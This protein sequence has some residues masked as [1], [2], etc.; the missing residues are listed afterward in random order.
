[1][2]D[3]SVTAPRTR[4]VAD[5]VAGWVWRKVEAFSGEVFDLGAH[6]SIGLSGGCTAADIV[7]RLDDIIR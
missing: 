4:M 3:D 1:M 5:P 2:P 7:E 6:G